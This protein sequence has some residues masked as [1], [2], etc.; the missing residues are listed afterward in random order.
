MTSAGLGGNLEVVG[1][2]ALSAPDGPEVGLL[3]SAFDY[4]NALIPPEAEAAR[5]QLAWALR[6]TPWLD[7]AAP[8]GEV[9]DL[10]GAVFARFLA[11]SSAASIGSR[12]LQSVGNDAIRRL[13]V[14]SPYWD[15]ELQAL[16]WLR[17]ALQPETVAVLLQRE[18]ALFPKKALTA[19]LPIDI[20]PLQVGASAKASRFVHAKIVIA[21]SDTADHV[22][23]G[24][25]N[26]TTAA[27]GGPSFIG[28]NQEAAL[29]R[30]LDPGQAVTIL[31]LEASLTA[32]QAV[33]PDSLPDL[34]TRDEIPLD[35]CQRRNSGLFELK[36]GI[37]T[38]LRPG[39]LTAGE[40]RIE[41][42]DSFGT[43]FL[44]E[45]T[46]IAEVGSCATF[47]LKAEVLPSFARLVMDGERFVPSV[48]QC[49]EALRFARLPTSSHATET[50]ILYL[51][52]PGTVE[53]L[54]LLEILSDLVR[55]DQEAAAAAGANGLVRRVPGE[56]GEP[57]QSNVFSY[58]EFNQRRKDKETGGFSESSTGIGLS[59]VVRQMLN[60]TLDI[61]SASARKQFEEKI[62]DLLQIGAVLDRGDETA[63][64]KSAVE[65]GEVVSSASTKEQKQAA[66]RLAAVRKLQESFKQTQRAII[67]AVSKYIVDERRTALESDLT[68]IS[69]LKLRV[70]FSV[71][72][73]TGC[74][75]EN[76]KAKTASGQRLV[77]ALLPC[78]G[79]NNWPLLA[80]KM[81]FEV[82][83]WRAPVAA[84]TEAQYRPL[85]SFVKLPM[86]DGVPKLPVDIAECLFLCQWVAQAICCAIDEQGAVVPPPSKNMAQLRADVYM[87][88]RN[89]LGSG[90]EDALREQTWAGLDHRYGEQ[91]GVDAHRIRMLHTESIRALTA[92]SLATS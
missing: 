1:Q 10:D 76:L 79:E 84:E 78:R 87:A 55:L 34:E 83:R 20:Y 58:D 35:E 3:R 17:N 28:K 23:F 72:L 37:L 12:F 61:R 68:P 18:V 14:V 7:G 8:T 33:T 57:E 81:L 42:L 65:K 48:V 51:E 64:R 30:R 5:E 2:V 75:S 70:L 73:A 45:L 67:T 24:S 88:S 31:G 53:N 29:Y 54:K 56:G 36:H 16:T 40:G 27:L 49:M 11:Y 91:L 32:D 85:I 21:Q 63:K 82:F 4:L 44:F 77:A 92:A 15:E 66:R 50:T 60:R 39:T 9:A 41:L 43:P 90:L 25:T 69:L 86:R 71:I 74:T 38:W 46:P 26:C 13:I 6:R 80:G 62:E 47:E 89:L 52:S 19:A 59:D 22:L